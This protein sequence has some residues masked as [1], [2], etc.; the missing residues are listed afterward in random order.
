MQQQHQPKRTY[1]KRHSAP[2]LPMII[3]GVI[4]FA[5]Y[6]WLAKQMEGITFDTTFIAVFCTALTLFVAQC[7]IMA[8]K[9]RKSS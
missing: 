4:L 6:I 2:S 8:F 7:F 5:L 9:A 1:K 3:S